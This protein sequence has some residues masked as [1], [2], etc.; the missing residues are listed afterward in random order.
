MGKPRF[1]SNFGDVMGNSP[2]AD[3]EQRGELRDGVDQQRWGTAPGAASHRDDGVRVTLQTPVVYAHALVIR[4][5]A[6]SR[7]RRGGQTRKKAQTNA[8]CAEV[9]W[10]R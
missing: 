2:I 5:N 7:Q 9:G 10:Q 6:R 8:I 1:L 3:R 4:N